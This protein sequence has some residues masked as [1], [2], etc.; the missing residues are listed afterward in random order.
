M[1]IPDEAPS[2]S[3]LMA[4]AARAR[5][6]RTKLV[7]GAIGVVV[8]GGGAGIMLLASHNAKVA[9]QDAWT[10][11]SACVIGEPLA[12]NERASTRARGIQLTVL[13]LPEEKRVGTNDVGWPGHCAERASAVV[14]TQKAL[15]DS[16]PIVTSAAKLVDALRVG[17]TNPTL[18]TAVDDAWR[19]AE[20]AGLVAQPL[21]TVAQATPTPQRPL[22]V[23][24]LPLGSK[25]LSSSFSLASIHREPF[26]GTTLRFLVDDKDVKEGP[27]LC[28][29]PPGTNA[30]KCRAIPGEA[31]K[32]SPALRLW[33][34]TEDG[35]A[36]LLF[37]GDRGRDG[38]YRSDTGARVED[39]LGN[40][41][42]GIDAR[43][44]GSYA[45]LVWN[46]ALSKTSLVV[47]SP[48]GKRVETPLFSRETDGNPYYN[49][50]IFWSDVVSKQYVD[51]ADGLH[52]LLRSI[53]AAGGVG[54]PND[55]GSVDEPSLVGWNDEYPHLRACKS[56]LAEV[57]GV[58]TGSSIGLSLFVGG[59]WTQ[60]I[61]GGAFPHELNCHGN[62]ATLLTM[63]GSI[64]HVVCDASSCKTERVAE[65]DIYAH[66]RDVTGSDKNVLG[67]DLGQKV[68]FT[69][70]AGTM[71][72]VRTRIAP[73]AQLTKAEDTV[74]F[75][76]KV[77]DG[78]M[79][80]DSTLLEMVDLT[81]AGTSLLFLRVVQGV[82]VFRFDADKG[83]LVPLTITQ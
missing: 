66:N 80:P 4:E 26:P 12:P 49:Q 53:D 44:D 3:D 63:S 75:D 15:D 71:A 56:S 6:R 21:K 16:R 20:K 41:A 43:K 59:K 79:K 46:E 10:D 40:G 11:L 72:G 32:M 13:G 14:E 61:D 31:A 8:L 78:V 57:L 9:A 74:F 69:W 68:A 24:T 5:S 36:P 51:G 38:I 25:L 55:I 42:Y 54:A 48:D 27:T 19:D 30:L 50:A 83:T 37:V 7:L 34:T 58:K 60:P 28:E 73:V 18:G 45:M 62:Q 67:T 22:T 47:V 33:G 82:F 65:A 70:L 39:K 81:A 76:D 2:S 1:T 52:V 17:P 23:D 29:M 35:A 64:T 77:Q